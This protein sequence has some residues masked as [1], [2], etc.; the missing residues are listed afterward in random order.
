MSVVERLD[1]LWQEARFRLYHP[2]YIWTWIDLNRKFDLKLIRPSSVKVEVPAGLLPDC[3]ECEECCCAGPNAVVS[4]RLRDIARLVDAGLEEFIDKVPEGRRESRPGSWAADEL[5]M[6]MF[7]RA[8]PILE[9]DVTG[10]CAL[11]TEDLKCGVLVATHTSPAKDAQWPI[12][13]A[14]YPYAFDRLRKRVFLARGCRSHRT[15]T[16]DDPPRSL[17]SLIDGAVEAYNARIKDI[18]LLHVALEELEE[19]G[20]LRFLHLE[21][22]LKKRAAKLQS[23]Q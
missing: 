5:D 8:F 6:S 18:I 2:R 4:L 7:S 23:G 9:R 19:L 12:S 20:L 21:G 15:M 11:L 17:V 10:T 13:C 1:A 16:L 22:R 3:V 14:R